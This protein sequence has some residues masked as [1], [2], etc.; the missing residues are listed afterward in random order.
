[1]ES[2][3]VTF[4]ISE[5]SAR[6][7][8]GIQQRQDIEKRFHHDRSNIVIRAQMQRNRVRLKKWLADASASCP[9]EKSS[10]D[11]FLLKMATK[12]TVEQ[13]VT[14]HVWINALN[15]A[16]AQKKEDDRLASESIHHPQTR[17]A[18]FFNNAPS[19]C[20][21][22]HFSVVGSTTEDC[23]NLPSE[24]A[25]IV[26][27]P[28]RLKNEKDIAL[29]RAD[30]VAETFSE[31]NPYTQ[32]A[33]V[34]ERMW[35]LVSEENHIWKV[36]CS[37]FA[38]WREETKKKHQQL[39][40]CKNCATIF[41]PFFPDDYHMHQSSVEFKRCLGTRS[42][43]G[44]CE[45]LLKKALVDLAKKANAYKKEDD[46]EFIK[47]I[48]AVKGIRSNR[49]SVKYDRFEQCENSNV[50]C[51]Y[52][53]STKIFQSH[54]LA[55]GVLKF[56]IQLHFKI[57]IQSK[58]INPKQHGAGLAGYFQRYRQFVPEFKDE[59]LFRCFLVEFGQHVRRAAWFDR[60]YTSR[61]NWW[62]GSSQD[63][64]V[65]SGL[66]GILVRLDKPGLVELAKSL[67][68][69]TFK[70]LNDF[71]RISKNS[72]FMRQ[73][74][75]YEDAPL[76]EYL[77]QIPPELEKEEV[78]KELLPVLM[79]LEVV[80][81]PEVRN[82]DMAKKISDSKLKKR[83]PDLTE[84]ELKVLEKKRLREQERRKKVSRNTADGKFR[85]CIRKIND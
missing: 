18:M 43:E 42:T 83:K 50:V 61:S 31:G 29:P 48:K 16:K 34:F 69:G 55:V 36:C 60:G 40:A 81:N 56:V 57:P 53:N 45:V 66:F 22:E 47:V 71:Y 32:R 11:D 39:A 17:M 10:T 79:P 85:L 80:A 49:S 58:F 41:S 52:S 5:N 46:K 35:M 51:C 19:M 30:E 76:H 27:E 12:A 15:K 73:V 24:S 7:L 54:N 28:V 2:P 4:I 9:E 21:S 1:M 62:S 23:E 33:N 14:E 63:N 78:E 64:F 25:P 72:D 82:A 13:A 3:N 65:D 68:Q 67:A 74:G 84:K 59:T 26:N 6:N 75:V 70:V 37:V 38:E 8:Q 20:M 44:D 77:E